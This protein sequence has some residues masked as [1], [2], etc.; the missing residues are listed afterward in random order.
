MRRAKIKKNLYKFYDFRSLTLRGR[1]FPKLPRKILPLRV[2][3]S[4]LP[5][6]FLLFWLGF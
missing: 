6:V 4:P 5:M 1:D 2:R 3:L